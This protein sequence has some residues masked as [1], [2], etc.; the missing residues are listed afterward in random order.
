L[1]VVSE[2]DVSDPAPGSYLYD[3]GSEINVVVTNTPV[4]AEGNLTRYD[5]T[6]WT[7]T[8]SVTNGVGTNAVFVIKQNSSIEW[9]WKTNYYLTVN[10]VGE[11]QVVNLMSFMP[12]VN[13]W[14]D[15]DATLMLMASEGE[16]LG[17]EGD[18]DGLMFMN[19]VVNVKMDRPRTI[20]ARFTAPNAPQF[21][22]LG[23]PLEWLEYWGLTDDPPEIAELTDYDGDGVPAWQEYIAGTCPTNSA[24]RFLITKIEPD[25]AGW[26]NFAWRPDNVPDRIYTM[27]GK[28]NL[29]DF[30]WVIPTNSMHRFFR[31][32][33]EKK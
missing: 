9:M 32:M 3:W 22:P 21:A 26:F 12:V 19:A 2:Y 24:D 4:F 28:T 27:E 30:S 14:H 1:D 17:W 18:M 16:F 29:N 15:V 10:V 25:G 20:T 7:G 8:G 13:A 31:I 6:A 33:V 11:G 23:T 5:C